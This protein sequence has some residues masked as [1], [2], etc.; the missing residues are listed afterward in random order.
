MVTAEGFFKFT[1]ELEQLST[2][3]TTPINL[4]YP[5][6][7][8][9][10]E[11]LMVLRQT[12][13]DIIVKNIIQ[14]LHLPLYI[15]IKNNNYNKRNLYCAYTTQ[16]VHMRITNNENMIRIT[17]WQEFTKKKLRTSER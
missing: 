11:A 3:R 16:Y 1:P 9:C 13:R 5:A 14:M 15:I 17:N 10:S 8:C 7:C 12:R 2:N 6:V 4:P